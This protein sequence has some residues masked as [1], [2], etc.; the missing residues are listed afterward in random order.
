[1]QALC[2]CFVPGKTG[3]GRKEQKGLEVQGPSCC[4]SPWM[5]PPTSLLGLLLRCCQG[6]GGGWDRGQQGRSSPASSRRSQPFKV[7]AG[8]PP[9]LHATPSLFRFLHKTQDPGS[10][11]ASGTPWGQLRASDATVNVGTR[12]PELGDLRPSSR[13]H[14]V[15]YTLKTQTQE[16]NGLGSNPTSATSLSD[17]SQAS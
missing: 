9:H 5:L 12:P 17:V 15:V 7:S 16:P 6:P 11:G 1:M 4:V 3:P 8:H 14:M 13:G 2:C 10:S